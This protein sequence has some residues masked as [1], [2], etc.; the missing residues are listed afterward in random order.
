MKQFQLMKP[1]RLSQIT[2]LPTVCT[3]NALTARNS[4]KFYRFDDFQILSSSL[5]Y[6]ALMIHESLLIA[7]FKPTFNVQGNS[8]PLKIL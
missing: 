5:D 3:L 6:C 2:C 8:I 4:L 1:L 7:K